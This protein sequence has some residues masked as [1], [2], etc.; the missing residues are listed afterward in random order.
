MPSLQ[1]Q[2][3]VQLALALNDRDLDDLLALVDRQRDALSERQLANGELRQLG[4]LHRLLA[5]SLG[6]ESRAAAPLR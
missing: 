5:E 4:R 6:R 3:R 2:R 1:L